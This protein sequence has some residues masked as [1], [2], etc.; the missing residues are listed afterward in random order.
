MVVYSYML[1]I[2]LCCLLP[3]EVY[4]AVVSYGREVPIPAGTKARYHIENHK[5]AG[6]YKFGYDTGS[7]PS[8][9]F[10][11][12]ERDPDGNVRG[13]YGYV[14][15][16][17]TLRVV[18]YKA[19]VGGFQVLRISSATPEEPRP[20]P[21]VRPPTPFVGPLPPFLRHQTLNSL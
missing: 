7:G 10:R 16:T 13:R 6:S 8:Q 11:Q 9:S 4:G 19:G 20:K 5:G 2:S 3:W 14:D 18:E 1:V 17:G 21:I 15:P 12:E